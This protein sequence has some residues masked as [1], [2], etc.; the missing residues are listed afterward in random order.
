M[1]RCYVKSMLNSTLEYKTD[2]YRIRAAEK[3]EKEI[4]QAFGNPNS[5]LFI[6]KCQ[7]VSQIRELFEEFV[8][9]ETAADSE[10]PF[11]IITCL[12]EVLKSDEVCGI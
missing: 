1:A 9:D 12:N 5:D 6:I 4:L 7:N 11:D 10:S 8:E 3:I 2:E